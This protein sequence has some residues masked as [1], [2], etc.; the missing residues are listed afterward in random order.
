[1][2]NSNKGQV[3]KLFIEKIANGK[4]ESHNSGSIEE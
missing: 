1:M 3:E 2:A 4:D